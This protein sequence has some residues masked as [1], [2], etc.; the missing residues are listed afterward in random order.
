MKIPHLRWW[1]ASALFLAAVLNYIDRN[2][3]GVLAPRIQQDLGIS[4]GQYAT[5]INF[6]LVA[7]TVAYL[8]SGRIVDKLGVRLS[9]ALFIGWWSVSNALTGLAHSARIALRVPVH[10]GAGR[11]GGLDCGA[12]GGLRVVPARR[13]RRGRGTLQR[14]RR[15][16]RDAGAG[17]GGGDLR[18]VWLALGIRGVADP[19]AL[20]AG[21]LALAL[22][23]AGE[24]SPHY[25]SG[26]RL[27]CGEP[28]GGHAP[29]GIGVVALGAR[30]AAS[31]WCGN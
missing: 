6:F 2:V 26:A 10:A 16:G 15:G 28:R 13:A 4:E 14:R 9:L 31:R 25:R 30:R 21:L 17:A 22:P 27:S 1:I 5:V 11:G 18:A 8:L 20:L 24:A 23:G 12:Q 29:R 3:L 7:Y 19:G